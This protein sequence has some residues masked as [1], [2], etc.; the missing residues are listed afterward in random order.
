M[1]FVNMW[2]T[3]SAHDI[4]SGR[5]AAIHFLLLQ[6]Y[7]VQVPERG[8]MVSRNQDGSLSAC[9][10]EPTCLREI[11]LEDFKHDTPL[12]DESFGES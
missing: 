4:G 9:E 2:G 6:G 5:N 7:R 3:V 1:K 8:L 10:V 12:L 11:T